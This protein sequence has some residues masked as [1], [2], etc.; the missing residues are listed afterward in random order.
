MTAI[1]NN[2]L[3]ET[4][5]NHN[6]SKLT[7]IINNWAGI[8]YIANSLLKLQESNPAINS[9][10]TFTSKLISTDT[11]TRNEKIFKLLSVTLG[12]T[13]IALMVT[14]LSDLIVSRYNPSEKQSEEEDSAIVELWFQEMSKSVDHSLLSNEFT[15]ILLKEYLTESKVVD[16]EELSRVTAIIKKYRESTS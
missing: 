12:I 11:D 13:H 4:H 3:Q 7:R 9:L 5:T 15:Q 8:N 16:R 14:L 1:T 6:S 10:F 2:Y